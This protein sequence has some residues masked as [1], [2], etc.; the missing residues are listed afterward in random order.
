MFNLFSGLLTQQGLARIDSNR[1]RQAMVPDFRITINQEGQP[2]PVLHELKVISASRTRYK[3]TQTERGV[4]K[5]ANELHGEY[6]AKAR[7]ADQQYG[8]AREGEQGRVECKLLSFPRVEGIVFGNW[9]EA[10]ESLHSLV[11]QIATSRARVAEPQ[12]RRKGGHLTEEGIK[13]MAVGYIR[14]R[15][16]VCGVKA[17]CMS[18]LGRLEVMGPGVTAAA[19]RRAAAIHRVSSGGGG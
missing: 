5:R 3:V 4:D 13:A 7:K 11:D 16:S 6:V 1:D 9:G 18:L 10:S 19:G 12:A 17:Q 15:L 14:R 2:Q 8:G